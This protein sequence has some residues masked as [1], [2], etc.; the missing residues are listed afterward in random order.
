MDRRTLL[1]VAISVE[2][3]VLY[4][5]FVL[6]QYAPAPSEAPVATSPAPNT[7]G[8]EASR[9]AP[10]RVAAAAAA[11][12][13]M[14]LTSPATKPIE[15]KQSGSKPAEANRGKPKLTETG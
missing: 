8:E 2:I 9:P 15:G 12:D 11:D 14:P 13:L 7:P 6:K 3:I 5:E 4:Q 1:F 10:P